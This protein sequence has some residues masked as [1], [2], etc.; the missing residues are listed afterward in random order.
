LKPGFLGQ[1]HG[2]GTG[3][4]SGSRRNTGAGLQP[5]GPLNGRIHP[6]LPLPGSR[7][8]HWGKALSGV[9]ETSRVFM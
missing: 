4:P 1:K 2:S 6:L 7:A 3:P 8:G 5:Q 9:R